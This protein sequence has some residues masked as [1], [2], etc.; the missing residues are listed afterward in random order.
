VVVGVVGAIGGILA[1]FVA[2]V[3][4]RIYTGSINSMSE[5]HNRLVSTHY[6]HFGNFLASK[7]ETER[8]REETL[9]KMAVELARVSDEA[10]RATPGKASEATE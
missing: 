9:S 4:L 10:V 1:N 2:A 7:I 3:F 8:L 5:F 6:L